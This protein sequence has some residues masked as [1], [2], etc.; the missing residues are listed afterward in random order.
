MTIKLNRDTIAAAYDLVRT[1]PP[2]D[3]W[4]LPEQE[5]VKFE[6]VRNARYFAACLVERK[7]KKFSP[8]IYVSARTVGHV[9]TLVVTMAHECIHLHM[10]ITGQDTRGANHNAA[11]Y[12][13]AKRVC[14]LNGFDEKAF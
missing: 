4:N 8:T 10:A 9:S 14:H 5:D 13:I 3:R 11:F 2:F 1:L 12:K 6:V 7:G